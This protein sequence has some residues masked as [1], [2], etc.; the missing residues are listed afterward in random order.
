MAR[1]GGGVGWAVARPHDHLGFSACPVLRFSVLLFSPPRVGSGRCP[2]PQAQQ[3]AQGPWFP[4]APL[5]RKLAGCDGARRPRAGPALW[6]ASGGRRHA[7]AASSGRVC[8]G[9]C[10]GSPQP[11]QPERA[12]GQEPARGGVR[13]AA[14]RRAARKR[15]PVAQATSRQKAPTRSCAVSLLGM[16]SGLPG[17]VGSGARAQCFP[18]YK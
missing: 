9:V 4:P 15:K 18:S 13:C 10:A 3:E 2:Q 7:G 11:A 6:S 1:T 16:V 12:W 8:T 17:R 14:P 5:R